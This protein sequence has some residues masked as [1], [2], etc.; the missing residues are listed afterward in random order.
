MMRELETAGPIELLRMLNYDVED[1]V[2]EEIIY[3]LAIR[4]VLKQM[5]REDWKTCTVL[6]L[7][8]VDDL[9]QEEIAY[10]FNM[11]QSNI[12]RRTRQGLERATELLN[13]ELEV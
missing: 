4:S 5:G 6:I 11:N 13:K 2:P 8:F 12:S 9:S 1:L 7:Q 10:K 3:L